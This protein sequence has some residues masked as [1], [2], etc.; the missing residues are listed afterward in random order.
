MSEDLSKINREV[1]VLRKQSAKLEE[2]MKRL[3]QRAED[4]QRKIE[5]RDKKKQVKKTR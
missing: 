2:E 5:L 4:L 3:V 1:Q